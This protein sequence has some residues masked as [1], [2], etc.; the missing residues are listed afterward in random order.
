MDYMGGKNRFPIKNAEGI[1]PGAELWPAVTLK[2]KG[3]CEIHCK[4]QKSQRA[5]G[6]N[7]R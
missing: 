4:K 1:E 7:R 5:K 6:R 3:V 2:G